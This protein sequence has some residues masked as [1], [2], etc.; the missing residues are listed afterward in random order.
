MKLQIEQWRNPS[1]RYRAK[2]FWAL[3]GKLEKPELKRQIETMKKMGFGGAFLHAR[4]GLATEYMS[5]EWMDDLAY[6]AEVLKENGMEAWI[7]DEDRWPSGT[8]GGYVTQKK[9]FREKS[10]TYTEVLPTDEYVQPENFLGLFAVTFDAENRAA[11]AY[12]KIESPRE[13]GAGERVFAFHYVYMAPETFYNGS[14]YVDTMNREATECFLELTHRRYKEVMGDKF[15]KEIV[16]V[17]TD[18]PHR[19]PYL[20][21]F[22][23]SEADRTLF[24]PYTY[25]L[26]ETFRTVMGYDIAQHLPVLWFGRENQP[27]C[28]EAYDLVE[29]M[30]QMFLENYAIPCHDWCVENKLIL[31]GHVLHEDNLCAQATMCGS[32][33]RFME[34][35]D[36]PGMDNLTATSYCY[37]VPALISSAAKQLGKEFVLDELYGITG[38]E[39]RLADYKH[40]GDWQSAGGVTLRCPHISW[41]TMK[42]E[43]KR[44]CPASIF[45]QSA[46]HEDYAYVEDYFSRFQYLMKNGEDLTDIAII[47]PIESVWG[48]V[49]QYTYYGYFE[50]D[51][52]LYQKIEE[53]YLQLY[54]QLWLRG[55]SMDYID[56]GLFQ[57]YGKAE[58]GRLICGRKGYR[59]I[60]LN[61]NYHLRSSTWNAIRAFMAQGGQVIVVG[62][63][64]QYLD[65]RPHDFSKELAGAVQ[66]PFDMDQVYPLLADPLVH[67]DCRELMVTSRRY[68]DEYVVALINASNAHSVHAR[69][70]IRT[71][72]NCLVLDC[73]TG[74][75]R[76][77]AYR[78]ENGCIVLNREFHRDE[79]LVLLLTGEALPPETR[80]Y[81][82]ITA[83]RQFAFELA[84][85]N[86]LLLDHGELTVDG[87]VYGDD[88]I[89]EQDKRV[90]QKFGLEVRNS[91]MLQPWFKEKFVP[92]YDR[93]QGKIALTYRF[94]AETLPEKLS[95]MCENGEELRI[96]L[97]GVPVSSEITHSTIDICFD[98]LRLPGDALRLGE[99]VLTV[100][101]DF[102]E[103]LNLESMYLLGNFGVR[104]GENGM[105][106]IIPLPEKL[107]YGDLRAQGLPYYGGT[108]R[109]RAALP[110][111]RYLATAQD[112]ECALA[113]CNGEALVFP[114][115]RAEFTVTE[116]VWHLDMTMTRKNTFGCRMER[117]IRVGM[118]PQGILQP[119]TLQKQ[120][121]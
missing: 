99:N 37:N 121:S 83:P 18:E 66:L 21:G 41:Y 114:P 44:D 42:G 103:R 87:E 57:K 84:E 91:E 30:Q 119:I 48:L 85:P 33:M 77:I 29:V 54:K 12:R 70:E 110:N 113:K 3:N 4:T 16:G 36:Y 64:P 45:H 104:C 108:V 107:T 40:V 59:K 8:C 60:I 116:G 49:N 63:L 52:P 17:F 11:R 56:E 112:V 79:E 95:L 6:A 76:G 78:R 5:E 72:K 25:K 9:E 100:E 58:N 81:E 96:K 118:I 71:D 20:N 90:R 68:D 14:T 73:R 53:E 86:M 35:M 69:I 94:R 39:M 115:Y 109:M 80:G 65:G 31:T 117:G 97:N 24:I 51:H 92:D 120:K 46:W 98:I 13:R 32:V 50:T 23:R 7:Y 1:A 106:T 89:L 43:G 27:F 111:G 93:V 2:P 47:N 61:G 28:K 22:G 67:T 102:H 101:A 62:D 75:K 26:F 82:E 105:D 55:I 74:Q 19:G 34:Y 10:M 15:G 88:S 38:W